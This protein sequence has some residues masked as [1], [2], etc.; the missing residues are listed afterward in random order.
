MSNVS[1]LEKNNPATITLPSDKPPVRGVLTQYCYRVW[2][3]IDSDR[4]PWGR[5]KT[6]YLN[7]SNEACVIIPVGG[8]SRA[9]VVDKVYVY[10]SPLSG[11]I[12]GFRVQ[13]QGISSITL[14]IFDLAGRKIFESGEVRGNTLIWNL[15]NNAE[16][17]LAN[18][19]YLYV[20][21]V[22]GLND[23]VYVSEVRK[24]VILR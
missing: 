22:R 17:R 6:D 16:Q 13:G 3:Y 15:Q 2:A 11:T 10:S 19:V 21:R 24:L 23:E 12:N 14:E 7:P 9:L 20:V 4:P 8:S 18:G 1:R 5:V